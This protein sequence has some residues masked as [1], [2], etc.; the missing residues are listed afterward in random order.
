MYEPPIDDYEFLLRHVIDGSRHLEITTAGEVKIDDVRDIL[1]GAATF[2]VDVLHPLNPIG[3][4]IGNKLVDGQV[5]TAPG[6]VEAF[7]AYAEAGWVGASA[8]TEAGG[9]GLP[10]V[11]VNVLN[12]LWNA[13]NAALAMSAGLSMA[14]IGAVNAAADEHI[15]D[16]YLAPLVAGRW[17]GT[18]NLTEPQA[19]TDL[20][21]IRMMA[22]PKAD[23]SWAVKGQ[24]IFITWGDH[25]M[26]DNI[27]HLVLARTPDAPEGLSGLSLFVV[28]KFLPDAQGEPGARNAITTVALEHKLGIN[29]SPTCVLDYDNAVGFLL[30]ERN[31]GLMAMFVMMN[32]TRVGTGLQGLGLSDKAYQ[33]ARDYAAQRIQGKVID[34]PAGT[35]I[36]EHPDVARL[37][38]SMA[39][40]VSGMRGFSIQ[41]GE[42]LDLA[43]IDPQAYQLAEF[44]VPVLK[45]W[46]TETSVQVTSD[47]IQ[48]HGG[49]GFIEETGAAQHYRDARILPIYEGTTAIQAK[50]LIGRKVLRDKGVTATIALDAVVATV[51]TLRGLEHPVAARTADRLDRA[52]ATT[53]RA[54]DAL[55]VFGSAGNRR[56]AAAGSVAYL[57][58]WGLLGG[59]WMHARILAAALANDDEH[60][61]RRISEADF[62]GAH[63]LSRISWLAETIEA[64][65]I[66]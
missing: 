60:T 50:D 43:A 41:V 22:R 54:T 46:F 4:R 49:A 14:A 48:V 33:Q 55:L 20:A 24:K 17:T 2:A 1:S 32:I 23:G 30:G 3:D 26:T 29:A 52:V 15:R 31:R 42:W 47:G 11:I 21:G 39:S 34:R 38:A 16:V 12:E 28:P 37:L 58:T 56:D 10:W 25:D 51:E 27:V 19:G 57:L 18:M 9:G 62:Y 45:G 6:T 13:A 40:I 61:A 44:F 59:G 65:E 35:P 8:P 53:R 64:G 36:A 63:H 66:A 7:R 5:I